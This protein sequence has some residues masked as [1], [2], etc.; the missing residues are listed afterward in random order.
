MFAIFRGSGTL[1]NDEVLAI[2]LL[3]C[4][5][6]LHEVEFVSHSWYFCK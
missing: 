5:F 4:H 1:A 2:N 6:Y 3:K